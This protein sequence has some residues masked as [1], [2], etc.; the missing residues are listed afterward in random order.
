MRCLHLADLHLGR[1]LKHY[2]L[3][4][5]QAEILEQ[6]VGL[7]EEHQVDCVLLAGD[8]FD[9]ARPEALAIELLG[10]FYHK[11]SRLCPVYAIAGNHDFPAHIQYLSSFLENFQIYVCSD[12]RNGI[13]KVQAEDEHG[14]V[15]VY[16]L[17]YVTKADLKEV[18]GER[19][20]ASFDD[21]M[22]TLLAGLDLELS[23]RNVLIAHQFLRDGI[24]SDSERS[25]SVGSS[26]ALSAD[27]FKDFD[28]V[29]LGHLHRPQAV[30][31][32]TVVY[33]GSPLPYSISELGY[34]KSVTLVDLGAK[35]EIKIQRLPIRSQS[36]F[37]LKRA[38]V[39]E[40]L[41][42]LPSEAEKEAYIYFKVQDSSYE[43]DLAR[44]LSGRYP[45]FLGLEYEQRAEQGL[46]EDAVLR[47]RM[48]Q[49]LSPME[50]TE[51]FFQQS[52]QKPLSEQQK[53]YLEAIW[54]QI[55]GQDET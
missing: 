18:L 43:R 27:L 37:R 38:K 28:Y 36:D 46:V 13:A 24:L 16:L 54:A 39:E 15:N 47:K 17:P 22:T 8:L 49:A 2:S 12:L 6:I 34:E 25:L 42:D 52:Q 1:R 14:V 50:A 10:D 31:R 19:E 4:D 21:Y 3:L 55:G 41:A 45:R 30:G 11:L 32:E 35:G 51:A 33:A 7:A 48:S 29:A 20:V 53:A 23:Q 5:E 44:V 9:S 26:F 40:L